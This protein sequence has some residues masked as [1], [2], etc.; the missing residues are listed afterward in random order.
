M[1]EIGQPSGD[2]SREERRRQWD[3]RHGEGDIESAD[4]NPVLVAEVTGLDAGSALDVGCGDGANAVWLAMHGWRVTAVD[5]S[6][7][8]LEKAR[9]RAD[10][11]GV[12]V[13]WVHADLLAWAPPAEAFD[14]VAILFL[15]LPPEERRRVYAGAARA[16]A[17]AGRLVVIGHDRTN[18]TDGVGGPRD[19]DRLFTAGEVA[20]ELMA[21][22]PGFEVRTARTVRRLAGAGPSPIDALLVAQRAP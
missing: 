6:V 17:P 14:L 5:W 11:A 22:A 2:E 19:P 4:A 8:G 20:A 12:E 7:V 13:G 15:H 3:E 9:R 1:D 10:A 21:D 18:L 16:V